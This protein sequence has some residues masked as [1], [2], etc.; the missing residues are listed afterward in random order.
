MPSVI[1]NCSFATSNEYLKVTGEKNECKR[2]KTLLVWVT[3]E[4]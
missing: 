3:E 2:K 4:K 1:E